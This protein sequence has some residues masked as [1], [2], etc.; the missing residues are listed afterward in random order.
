LSLAA[1]G[2]LKKSK[3]VQ[4]SVYLPRHGVRMHYLEREPSRSDESKKN[5]KR[6]T[7]RTG[8]NQETSG[9]TTKSK[10]E[11]TILFFH[12]L[13]DSAKNMA[14]FVHS[15]NVPDHIR[16]LVPDQ[17]GHGEDLKRAKSLDESEASYQHP[18]QSTLL[19]S[20][21][22]F[23]DVVG[24]G[25]NCNAFGISLGG[26]LAYFIRLKRPDVIKR[27]VLVSPAIEYCI[28]DAFIDDFLEGRKR[29]MCFENRQDVK[30]LFRDL[31]TGRDTDKRKRKDPVPK[32]FLEAVY[33][34]SKQ[35]AP[36]GHYKQMLHGLIDNIGKGAEDGGENESIFSADKDVDSTSPRLV[37]WPDHD[38]I[39]N[40]EK[41]RRFFENSIQEDNKG[42]E[43]IQIPDC[44]H[45]FHRDGKIILQIEWVVKK[46]QDYLFN[47]SALSSSGFG[48][49]I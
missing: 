41:G 39:C 19:E 9:S 23:L 43:W 11:P 20:T 13:S 12:G 35:M 42:T 40:Y 38:Y 33:R 14:G 22:E 6:S 3:L 32:F 30:L 46:I 34:K 18:T 48:S 2:A 15:L 17:F 1:K 27:T 31:S 24:V 28:D 5:D 44:G 25:S 21:S 26:A 37:I 36:E 10:D 47:F 49:Q 29:H 45:V 8:I 16:I 7:T 4:K